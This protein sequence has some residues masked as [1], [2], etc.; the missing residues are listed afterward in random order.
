VS[1]LQPHLGSARRG[2]VHPPEPADPG[3]STSEVIK[4]VGAQD[5]TAGRTSSEKVTSTHDSDEFAGRP[6]SVLT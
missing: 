6:W 2:R 5:R 3:A 1:Q 4:D